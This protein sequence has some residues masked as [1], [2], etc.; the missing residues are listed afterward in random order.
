MTKTSL[1]TVNHVGK[2]LCWDELMN[3]GLV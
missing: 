2:T 1:H 3:G